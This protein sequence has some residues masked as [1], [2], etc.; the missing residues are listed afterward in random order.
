M[1]QYHTAFS[2]PVFNALL[3]RCIFLLGISPGFRLKVFSRHFLHFEKPSADN[4]I[5]YGNK[6]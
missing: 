5:S 2:L 4:G 1:G 3:V 6:C